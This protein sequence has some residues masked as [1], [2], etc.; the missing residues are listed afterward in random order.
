MEHANYMV[1]NRGTDAMAGLNAHTQRPSLPGAR[2]GAV[3]ID[4]TQCSLVR[5]FGFGL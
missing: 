4:Q 5:R 3:V 1:Q 2:A